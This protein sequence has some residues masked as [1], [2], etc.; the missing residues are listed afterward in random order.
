MRSCA[1]R[2]GQR[3]T[4]LFCSLPTPVLDLPV[5]LHGCATPP[6]PLPSNALPG[7][8]RAHWSSSSSRVARQSLLHLARAAG[9]SPPRRHSR[10]PA[11]EEGLSLPTELRL[12][13]RVVLCS[14]S[15]AT[16]LCFRRTGQ[17][18][19]AASFL[20]WRELPFER[21]GVFGMCSPFPIPHSVRS[22][23]A[24]RCWSFLYVFTEGAAG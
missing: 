6:L 15:S 18:S 14:V 11:V 19:V 2:R 24:R 17:G 1:S 4:L 12:R 5:T 16:L 13:V 7:L 8:P 9:S 20:G 21:L 22:S 3:A 23:C 10:G